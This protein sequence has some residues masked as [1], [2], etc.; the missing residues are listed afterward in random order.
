MGKPVV[1]LLLFIL[2]T[3]AGVFLSPVGAQKTI[4][5]P[6]D[7][8][9]ITAAVEN[10]KDGNVILIRPGVYNEQSLKSNHSIQL[11][12]QG[13]GTTT[14]NLHPPNITTTI[15]TSTFTG[16][17]NAVKFNGDN[18][19]ISGLTFNCYG[20]FLVSGDNIQM[21]GNSINGYQNWIYIGGNRNTVANN[22]WD[23][24]LDLTGSYSKAYG[25]TG[26]GALTIS[27]FGMRNSIF[28][29]TL[30]S[31]GS[32]T[33]SSQNL[34]YCNIIK[35][36]VGLY[37]NIGDIVYNNTVINCANG[38]IMPGGYNNTVIGN[39]V[40]NN[41]GTGLSNNA[42]SQGS[43]PACGSNNLFIGNYV[44]GN[45]IGVLIDTSYQGHDANFTFYNNNFIDNVQQTQVIASNSS[46]AIQ[47][48][49]FPL[50][51]QSDHWDR[52]QIG[53]YWNDYTIRYPNA[54]QVNAVWDT[55]YSV[56]GGEQDNYP[57]AAA[58]DLSGLS[59]Q[60]PAWADIEAS[61]DLPT[62][63]LPST[64]SPKPSS[65]VTPTGL[66]SS[67][68]SPTVPEFTALAI[69]PIIAATLIA[70]AL[71][72]KRSSKLSSRFFG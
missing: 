22:T 18:I 59:F 9:T 34:F 72:R 64:Q 3:S 41:N 32:A 30:S 53:N 14:I 17:D 65:L 12:G 71:I 31:V 16:P 57:L 54:S 69:L 4:V 56:G 6:D 62:V 40:V 38:I 58:F 45:S 55:P 70:A 10:A 37:A 11:R 44:S 13:I 24:M 60:L 50:L 43:F 5:V 23:T 52:N 27:D 19:V 28:E 21:V 42:Y 67:S 66:P 46:S 68:A 63:V 7:Y 2:V 26:S 36:G 33:I 15:F 1:F 8:P 49:R 29:N 35:N 51:F 48:Y 39:K 47:S 61:A 25:N 20:A